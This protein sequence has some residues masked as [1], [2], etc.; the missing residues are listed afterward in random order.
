MSPIP[1]NAVGTSET[2]TFNPISGNQSHDVMSTI[3][4]LLLN[5]STAIDKAHSNAAYA[6]QYNTQVDRFLAKNVVKKTDTTIDYEKSNSKVNFQLVKEKD[7]TIYYVG[8]HYNWSDFLADYV[9]K[10]TM[11]PEWNDDSNYVFVGRYANYNDV[12]NDIK[13]TGVETFKDSGQFYGKFEGGNRKSGVYTWL[14]NST[15]SFYMGDLN[16]NING[17]G[18]LQRIDGSK[19]E[20]IF[21]LFQ[22]NNVP[23]SYV[24]K[25]D[26]EIHW[27][28]SNNATKLNENDISQISHFLNK[29]SK[30]YDKLGI[31]EDNIQKLEDKT[32]LNRTSLYTTAAL[33]L[34]GV[35][36]WAYKKYKKS[37]TQKTKALSR[38]EKAAITRKKNKAAKEAA[39][40]VS[41][42][43][44][45]SA[46]AM[47]D[48][49]GSGSA[50]AMGSNVAAGT[51]KNKSASKSARR[52]E[53]AKKGALTRAA[54][55][56][57]KKAAKAA[58]VKVEGSNVAW[59]SPAES[60]DVERDEIIQPVE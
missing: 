1:L 14:G 13:D 34:A 31:W 55:K 41:V 54:N 18:C 24:L 51:R 44:S 59:S 40:S 48:N 5:C 3:K 37:S 38:G 36:F 20:F 60:K 9:G 11:K 4:E 32:G 28:D 6:H 52:S 43:G 53:A 2:L 7:P 46:S 56:A 27:V 19:K 12:K 10:W 49:A 8:N 29:V 21:G 47:E 26:K 16:D 42:S 58:S 45:N 23:S 50:S 35:G 39:A 17:H 33:A 57:A 15:N 25:K 22:N 30:D